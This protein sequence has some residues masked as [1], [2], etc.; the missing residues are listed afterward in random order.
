M[1]KERSATVTSLSVFPTT[2]G[3]V[4]T[5]IDLKGSNITYRFTVY[6]LVLG[7]MKLQTVIICALSTVK[8]E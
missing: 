5:A 3:N 6:S 1:K 2:I 8:G 4:I 7:K